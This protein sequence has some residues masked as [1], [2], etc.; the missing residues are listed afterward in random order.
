LRAK[1]KKALVERKPRGRENYHE[2]QDIKRGRKK[3][4]SLA[5]TKI[6]CLGELGKGNGLLNHFDFSAMNAN[7]DTPAIDRIAR[8]RSTM[9]IAMGHF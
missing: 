8:N 7:Q 4:E 2:Y 5:E 9:T 6:G 1:H 3:W